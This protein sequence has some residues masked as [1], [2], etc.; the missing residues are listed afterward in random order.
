MLLQQPESDLTWS[1]FSVSANFP[2]RWSDI[3]PPHK[4][5]SS[6]QNSQ[7]IAS[8]L[9]K[10]YIPSFWNTY[11]GWIFQEFQI[12]IQSFQISFFYLFLMK[13]RWC[14]V[15]ISVTSVTEQNY[16]SKSTIAIHTPSVQEGA[17]PQVINSRRC[18]TVQLLA[19]ILQVH[20]S[21]LTKKEIIL[22]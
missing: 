22:F 3:G 14:P 19:T 13:M 15:F 9:N 8:I 7:H 4:N 2:S 6:V 20:I 1:N 10:Q 17:L 5:W 21:T 16:C 18:Q 11:S 12:Y